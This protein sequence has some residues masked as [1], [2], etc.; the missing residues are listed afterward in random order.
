MTGEII[1]PDIF[2]VLFAFGL[3]PLI[4]GIWVAVDASSKPDAA[5]ERAG[6]SKTLW[7]VLPLVGIF[8]CVMSIIVAIIWFT[9]IRPKVVAASTA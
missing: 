2:I 6:T 8:V 1:G 4:L 7:I 5:F 3:I 9:A